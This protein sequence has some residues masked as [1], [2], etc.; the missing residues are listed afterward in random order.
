[1]PVMFVYVTASSREEALNIGRTLVGER[2]AACANIF[3]G[4]S[5]IYWW[6]GR[7][8]EEGEVSLILK[9]TSDLI[10]ALITRVKQ[11]HSYDCPCVVALPIAQG[12]PDYLDWIDKETLPADG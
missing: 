3:D 10:P 6:Q 12:N 2:L 5:S 1:M 11:L 8:I 7:L 9:S 4:V